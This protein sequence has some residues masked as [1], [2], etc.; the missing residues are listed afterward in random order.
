M[1]YTNELK[2]LIGDKK[3]KE[4][5]K[6]ID[7]NLD[8][9]KDEEVYPNLKNK[10]LVIGLLKKEDERFE[11]KYIDTL[12]EAYN[13]F[14]EDPDVI[15]KI[16]LYYSQRNKKKRA[17]EYY[18]KALLLLYSTTDKIIIKY[19]YEQLLKWDEFRDYPKLII[20]CSAFIVQLEYKCGNSKG[21]EKRIFEGLEYFIKN[22]ELLVKE[23]KEEI[24]TLLL[25]LFKDL[26]KRM[27]YYKII[28]LY[29][30]NSTIKYYMNLM[31]GSKAIKNLEDM[32]GD[33]EK[34]P[35]EIKNYKINQS[36]VEC[37]NEYI[38]DL[39][40]AESINDVRNIWNNIND[41]PYSVMIRDE[42]ISMNKN[43]IE[44]LKS[45]KNID[46]I[47]S[48]KKDYD[49]LDTL[50]NIEAEGYEEITNDANKLIDNIN[51]IIE[52][53]KKDLEDMEHILEKVSKKN[54]SEINKRFN[55]V[56][57]IPLKNKI[58][59]WKLN[60]FRNVLMLLIVFWIMGT[61]VPYLIGLAIEQTLIISTVLG[62]GLLILNR[63]IDKIIEKRLTIKYIK[64][65][66]DFI[67]DLNNKIYANYI[68]YRR[69]QKELIR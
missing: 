33:V 69:L 1:N 26:Y 41:H 25:L 44:I 58:K 47:K 14:N 60:I 38:E 48:I 29:T 68:F 30:N 66:E 17:K 5:L 21:A 10:V 9:C 8:E 42:L 34:F 40:N 19:G 24:I 20:I 45:K 37:R 6:L 54:I 2:K 51:Y 65:L 27:D 39:N 56:T 53:G 28:E 67:D 3:L 50:E 18:E 59:W 4:A 11:K 22:H 57:K 36:I 16:G 46:S 52:N 64:F 23:Q 15:M 35:N 62:I 43:V 61:L 63:K 7:K 12:E 55:S 31:A 49:A 32:K 13:V